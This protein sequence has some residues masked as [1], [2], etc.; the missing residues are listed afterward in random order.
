MSMITPSEYVE[1]MLKHR[2]LII[3]P[4]DP[5][6]LSSW[7]EIPLYCDNRIMMS[8]PIVVKRTIAALKDILLQQFPTVWAIAGV[9]TAGI[10]PWAIL[11]YELWVPFIYVRPEPKKHWLQKQI[12]GILPTAKTVVVEDLVFVGDSSL[13]VVDVLRSSWVDVVGVLS[14]FSYELDIAKIAFAE[15]NVL[16]YSLASLQTLIDTANNQEYISQSDLDVICEW[17]KNPA[18]RRKLPAENK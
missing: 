6:E 4:N 18:T 16:H 13:K 11:A 3:R 10:G 1:E 5:V 15:K 12:E 2:A 8:D 17:K 14:V 9:S 7:R